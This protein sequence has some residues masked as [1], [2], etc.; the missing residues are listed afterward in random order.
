MNEVIFIKLMTVKQAAEKWGV[1]PRR[2]QI[3]IRTGR[4][5]KAYKLERDWVMPDNT[6]KPSDL[7]KSKTKTKTE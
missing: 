7:R 5:P 2:V 3:L 4:I 6:Q 1:T